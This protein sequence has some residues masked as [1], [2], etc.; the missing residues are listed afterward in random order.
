MIDTHCHLL[1]GLD[2]G[3][4]TAAGA[5][6]LARRLVAAG[7]ETAVCT[8]HF[9]RRYPTSAEAARER[10]SE[11]GDALESSGI[12]LGLR[13]AAEVAPTLALQASLADL[14]A[15]SVG[16]RFVIVE[17][18]PN[19]PGRFFELAAAHLSEGQLTPIFAHP[20]RCKAVHRHTAL[21]RVAR[22]EG[23]L[24]QIVA[25]SLTGKWG[26]SIRSI[27]WKLLEDG[28][29]DLLGSDAHGRRRHGTELQDALV[30]AGVRA[31]DDRVA[32]LM[33]QTPALLLEGVHPRET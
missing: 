6:R 17:V 4:A 22:D 30:L 29:V 31:G 18:Q 28:L 7:I 11:L 25:P 21:L 27:A 9:S 15:R 32:E 33:V 16:G 23:G 26:A 3:P 14:R 13:L 24:I 5:V 1:H 20:E 10:L 8:P 2:D 12:P 19:T